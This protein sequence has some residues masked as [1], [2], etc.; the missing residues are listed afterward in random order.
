MT[1]KNRENESL[2]FA[3]NSKFDPQSLKSV[4]NDAVSFSPWLLCTTALYKVIRMAL[5]TP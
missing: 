4:E 1:I 3:L 2:V 5:W